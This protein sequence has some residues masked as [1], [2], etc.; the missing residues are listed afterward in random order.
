MVYN[1]TMKRIIVALCILFCASFSGFA[2]KVYKLDNGLKLFVEEN[3]SVPLTYI[4]IAVKCGSYTQTEE[5]AGVFHL[6]EHMMFKGNS[7]YKDAASVN[8]ALSDMGVA[9]W[10][11]TTG[12]E[13]VN[14]YFT[15]PKDMTRTGLEFWNAAIRFPLLDKKEFEDEKKVVISEINGSAGEPD[16]ILMKKRT[17]LIFADGP[18]T[19]SPSGT[20][21]S[22]QQATIKQLKDMQ[23]KFYIPNNAALFVGGDVDPDEVYKMVKEI[24]GSW[25]KGKDPFAQGMVRHEKNPF[26][27]PKLCVMP[28]DKMSDQL[29]QILVEFR[30][31][32]AAYDLEDTY[33]VDILSNLMA[34]PAGTF[35]Q[36]LVQDPLIGIPDTD[37]TGGGYQTRKT[38]GVLN[39]YGLVVQPELDMAER[40]LYFAENLSSVLEKTC[41]SV[42]EKDLEK[43]C[44]RL[45]DDDIIATQTATGYLS[46][47]RFW[48]TTCGEDYYYN[49]NKNMGKV[50]KTELS[51][52]VEKYVKGK[53]PLITVLVSPAVYEQTKADFEKHGFEEIT[54]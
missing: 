17:E 49:Y 15:V 47:L 24:F 29:A 20:E 35:K 13:C 45:V 22:V 31:P 52:F 44:N 38:C 37:Y 42:S 48:W 54:K 43:I 27:E 7:L 32:D 8:R 25:K 39:F 14:Y 5:T 40:A 16:H 30:G 3:H 26:L 6:Y 34:N 46:T 36:S 21:R 41:S 28:Y 50:G 4:E 1:M 19:M 51:C 11:G 10:N 18:F 23:K 12:L 9:E 53:N 2:D 33:A